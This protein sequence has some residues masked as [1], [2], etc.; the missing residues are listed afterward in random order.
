MKRET[1]IFFL[2]TIIIVLIGGFIGY[3]VFLQRPEKSLIK[4]ELP[5]TRDLYNIIDTSGTIHVAE[6][7]KI[8]SLVTGTLKE[9]Y[10]KENK[11]VKKGQLLAV[12][13]TG[14]NKLDVILYEGMFEKARAVYTY[15]EKFIARQKEL[16]RSGQLAKDQFDRMIKDYEQS[17]AELKTA[18]AYYEKAKMEYDNTK[19]YAPQDGIIIH[20]GIALGERVTT[21]LNATILFE[22]AKDITKMQGELEIDES[23]IGYIKQGQKVRFTVESYP[24]K[25]FK[26]VIKELSYSP[27]TKNGNHYYK[28]MMDIDNTH[29]LFRPGMTINAQITV[30]KSKKALALTSQAFMINPTALR[31]VAQKKGFVIEELTRDD[32]KQLEKEAG[33]RIRTVWVLEHDRFVEKAITTD[34]TDNI[35]FQVTSGISRSSKIITDVEETDYMQEAL[36]KQFKSKF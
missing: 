18:Q 30:A 29:E 19:I 2:S 11:R 22:I 4:T 13:D 31:S 15:Q 20:V 1:I 16:Y 26:S 24:N 7:I 9:L 12:I 21:D 36:K 32:K 6:K 3:K 25:T 33:Q 28:A 34:I 10:A 8:G 23:D 14:K 17:K 35:Y 5:Q 27:K